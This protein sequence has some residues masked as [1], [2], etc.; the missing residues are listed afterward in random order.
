MGSSSCLLNL[1]RLCLFI[2]T[3]G[4][5]HRL[6]CDIP[7]KKTSNRELSRTC[8]LLCFQ[9]CFLFFIS[10]DLVT[11]TQYSLKSSFR[12]HI[13]KM[14]KMSCQERCWGALHDVWFRTQ[15]GT[16]WGGL[17]WRRDGE[18][19]LSPQYNSGFCPLSFCYSDFRMTL[20]CPYWKRANKTET[21]NER[22]ESDLIGLW[23]GYKRARG[24]QREYSSKP[25]KN[26]IV[27]RILVFKR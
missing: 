22:K 11:R 7:W 3:S 4:R 15:R 13:S 14:T 10:F 9:G 17:L 26:S 1:I 18:W 20:Y 19:P 2:C 25:L 24:T 6:A 8:F 12:L 16:I 27:K 21:T 5:N 23:N